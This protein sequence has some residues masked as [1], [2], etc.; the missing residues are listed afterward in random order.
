[1]HFSRNFATITRI[2]PKLDKYLLI[3]A[4]I[5]IL[6]RFYLLIY[7]IFSWY[8]FN[9]QYTSFQQHDIF[10]DWTLPIYFSTPFFLPKIEDRRHGTYIG[11]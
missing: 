6:A 9:L 10:T 3:K 11:W 4:S 5:G 8:F 1:M 7:Y 2:E